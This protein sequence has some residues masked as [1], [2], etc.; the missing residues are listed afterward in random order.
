MTES[1]IFGYAFLLKG[2]QL[3]GVNESDDL[4]FIDI[5]KDLVDIRL[6]FHECSSTNAL[7]LWCVIFR[8][9]FIMGI[10]KS[11]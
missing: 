8:Q 9:P 7:T 11:N 4:D 6:I 2:I 3:G 1:V 10:S 5:Q